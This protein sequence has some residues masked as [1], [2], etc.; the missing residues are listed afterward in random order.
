[1]SSKRRHLSL[2]EKDPALTG[3]CALAIMTKAPLGG[4]V[5]TRLTPPLTPPEAAAMNSCFLQDI[6]A[7]ITNAG[8]QT[9][10]VGCYT[11]VGSEEMFQGLLPPTF[12]LLRQREGHFGDR[13]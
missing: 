8:A 13:L 12:S 2:K 3:S 11:P 9:R 4:R 7:T 5:K 10:G 6:A 1:M